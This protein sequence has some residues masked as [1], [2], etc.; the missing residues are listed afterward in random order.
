MLW[1]QGHEYRD[2][3]ERPERVP[4]LGGVACEIGAKHHQASTS[5]VTGE[6]DQSVSRLHGPSPICADL[7]QF[8][9]NQPQLSMTTMA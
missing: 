3:H 4:P 6:V 9:G 5:R 7:V 8:Y 1:H 2:N